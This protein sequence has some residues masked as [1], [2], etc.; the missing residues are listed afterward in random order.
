MPLL[1]DPQGRA[2][3]LQGAGVPQELLSDLSERLRQD[4]AS[5]SKCQ[6]A[7]TVL[8]RL[9]ERGERSLRER[10]QVLRRV[11]EFEYFGACWPEDQTKARGFRPARS[12]LS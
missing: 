2:P 5:V 4:A 10:R 6:I 7:R 8:V 1:V 9:N 12:G 11:C 3:I